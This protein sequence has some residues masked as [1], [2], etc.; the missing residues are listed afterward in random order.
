MNL[1]Q[2]CLCADNQY[3]QGSTYSTEVTCSLCTQ[4]E[5]IAHVIKQLTTL[6]L[7]PDLDTPPYV[8]L[9]KTKE[10]EVRRYS[11]Y[12]VAETAM[13]AGARPAGGS[14]F[15]ELAGYIFGGNNRFAAYCNA[16]GVVCVCVMR[17]S[18]MAMTCPEHAVLCAVDQASCWWR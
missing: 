6:Q 15:Q 17:S 14:G 2:A 13:P 10:Y 18:L 16:S 8:V 5:G 11:S 9:K 7:T 1:V 12:L 3:Q 4:I